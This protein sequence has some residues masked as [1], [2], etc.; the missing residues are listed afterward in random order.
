MWD[1]PG[2]E[3]RIR[4]A[5]QDEAEV[6]RHDEWLRRAMAIRPG[7]RVLDIGCGTGQ[8]TR[9]AARVAAPGPVLGVD[10]SGRMLD[11]ARSLSVDEGLSNVSFIQADA[12]TYSFPAGGFDLALSRFGVMFFADPVAAFTN[13]GTALCPTGRLVVMV[14]QARDR[15]EWATA[16]GEALDAGGPAPAPTGTADAFSLGDRDVV[17]ATLH[18]AGFA[19]VEFTDVHEPVYFGRDADAAYSFV[20]GLWSTGQRLARLDADGARRAESALRAAV[21]A[22]DTG[23]G[24]LF[25]SRAW[26]VAA[27]R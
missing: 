18:A 2:G 20:R 15:N 12:Q 7:E 19:D 3:H 1:G 10:L 11:R 13:I 26:I 27:R 16:I 9:Y 21:A 24:V 8:T 25:D 4:H 23:D 14:W 17:T 22:H 5:D 6:R